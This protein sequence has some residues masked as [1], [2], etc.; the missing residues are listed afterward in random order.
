MT[1]TELIVRTQQRL[2]EMSLQQVSDCCSALLESLADALANGHGVT[3]PRVGEFII[4]RHKARVGSDPRNGKE[5]TI[6]SCAVVQ[7]YPHQS[8]KDRLNSKGIADS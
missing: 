2:P 6:P 3:L 7:F 8:V 5:R 4:K 1:R